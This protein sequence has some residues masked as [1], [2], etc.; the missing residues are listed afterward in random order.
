MRWHGMVGLA[1]GL[2]SGAA[3]AATLQLEV[4]GAGEMVTQDTGEATQLPGN[5]ASVQSVKAPKVIRPGHRIEGVYCHEFGF[6]FRATNLPAGQTATV[7]VQLTHPLWT[8]PDGRTGTQE[9]W[10]N[11]LKGD[12]WSYIGY[13]FS[14]DWSLVP[15]SW[16]YTISQGDHVL[17]QQNFQL[18]VAPGQTLPLQGCAA[19]VS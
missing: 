19:A 4:A 2:A 15:G 3:H 17:T 18:D 5:L 7:S 6:S 8:L 13:A 14:E 16:E 9:V 10:T 1:F 11:T 12:G